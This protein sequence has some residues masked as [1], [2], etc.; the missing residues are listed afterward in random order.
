MD[1]RPGV[2]II[3]L[4]RAPDRW[5]F[6]EG[7]MRKAGL[8]GERIQAVDRRDPAFVPRGGLSVQR[9]DVLRETNWDGRFYVMGEEACFQS[10]LKALTTFIAS[11]RHAGLIMEDDC[12]MAPDF[13]ETLDAIMGYRA[14]WDI[15]KLEGTRKK[16]GRPAL[17]VAK[18]GQ[19]DLVASL[20]PSSGAAAYLVTQA[21][22]VRLIAA[23][24]GAYEPFD[25][26]LSAHW[27]HG[28]KALDCSPFPARQGLTESTR[29]EARGPTTRSGAEKFTA[30]RRHIGADTVGRYAMRWLSQPRRFA[31]KWRGWT[32][33]RWAR[34]DWS[35]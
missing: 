31:G 21:A 33:A 11:G 2:Y 25:N 6:M 1:Q 30:W 9:D 24:E 22:A 34:D 29:V 12:E 18:A 15:V 16:G 17:K 8:E 26:F 35:S 23:A 5:A 28:L 27:R 20:N 13:A 14:L 4:D 3:N 7:Q 32:I 10:H 19:Y